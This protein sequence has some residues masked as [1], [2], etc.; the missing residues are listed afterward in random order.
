MNMY[1][2][3]PTY[4]PPAWRAEGS[5]I[6]ATIFCTSSGD[7]CERGT[8]GGRDLASDLGFQR[9][10]AT[11]N[12]PGVGGARRRTLKPAEAAQSAPS[13]PQMAPLVT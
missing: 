10:K 6:P 3:P 2:S 4:T 11:S 1:F 9:I 12:V 7:T 8:R 5:S 13:T